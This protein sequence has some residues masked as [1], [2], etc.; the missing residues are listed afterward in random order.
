M[1]KIEKEK[2]ME[3]VTQLALF[4]KLRDYIR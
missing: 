3:A 4:Q 1:D 2:Q